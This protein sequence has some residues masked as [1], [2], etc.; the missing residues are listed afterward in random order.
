MQ[1][2][3]GP[4]FLKESKM[5]TK[6]QHNNLFF[7]TFRNF[8]VKN[9]SRRPVRQ[10]FND[11][12][13]VAVVVKNISVTSCYPVKILIRAY[14]CSLVVLKAVFP[15]F[16][17]ETQTEIKKMKSKPNLKNLGTTI[18]RETKG[19]YNDSSLKT[20]K[21]PNPI[22]TQSK[23]NPNLWYCCCCFFAFER[24]RWSAH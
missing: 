18:T 21:K 23:A 14:W 22:Q 6:S 7:L 2:I 3:E 1:S 19:A 24:L 8:M 9:I 11:G 4:C 12:S 13:V 17:S 5:N 15:R 16:S 20:A 10:C